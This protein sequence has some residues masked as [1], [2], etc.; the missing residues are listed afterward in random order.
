MAAEEGQPMPEIPEMGSVWVAWEDAY[1]F[2][3]EEQVE[4]EEAFRSAADQIR[5]LIGE[6]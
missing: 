5:G 4:P 6:E 3:F 2:I 1:A